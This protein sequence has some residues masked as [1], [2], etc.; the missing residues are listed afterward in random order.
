[1]THSLFDGRLTIARLKQLASSPATIAFPI[2]S[3]LRQKM[4]ENEDYF[5]AHVT[6]NH[7]IYGSTSGFG[8]SSHRSV[9]PSHVSSLQKNLTLYH[10]CGVGPFCS[11]EEARATTIARLQT[12]IQCKSGVRYELAE[13]IVQLL[14]LNVAPA[15]PIRGSVGASGDLTPLSYLAAAL[16][17][18]GNLIKPD[19]SV[20]PTHQLVATGQLKPI[21]LQGREGLALMN[22]TSFMTA[23]L[24][25][26]WCKVQRIADLSCQLTAMLAA[27]TDAYATSFS[28]ALHQFKP[29]RGTLH[30]ASQI[31]KALG[32]FT[33]PTSP[34]FRNY[35]A[36]KGIQDPYSIR[37][38]PHVIGVLYDALEYSK[39][40]IE[41]EL[42]AVTDNPVFDDN[43]DS[44]LNG[45][46]FFGG[47][48]A[49]AADGLKM[50]LASVANLLDRQIAL[51]MD[52]RY[53]HFFTEN[54]TASSE[55]SHPELHH[56]FKAMQITLSAVTAEIMKNAGPCSVM[57]RPTESS[58]QDVVSMGTLAT[59][60]LVRQTELME[61][62]ISVTAIGLMQASFI[63]TPQKDWAPLT[64]YQELKDHFRPL[65]FDRPLDQ[66]ILAMQHRLFRLDHG[67][68]FDSQPKDQDQ[69]SRGKDHPTDE[70]VRL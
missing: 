51:L 65:I 10:Q 23:V 18:Q 14:N 66:D 44:V 2:G 33:L 40:F 39:S 45:G 42:N 60:D 8:A 49:H 59:F 26:Q 9:D 24:S 17:G 56:A 28:A 68:T 53:R 58:N 30:A 61:S 48:M 19:Q 47:H 43:L 46:H 37:C 15:I 13:S 11:Y 38:A 25:L 12:I 67:S 62:I 16:Q 70:H 1:M 36:S 29:H 5:A 31:R 50:A 41:I 69:L 27:L 4:A 20:I 35:D 34:V 7:A 55:L 52:G 22:G 21:T 64:L 3:S 63:R 57:S 6:K 54:L 32:P